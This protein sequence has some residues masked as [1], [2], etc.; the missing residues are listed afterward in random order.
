MIVK[1]GKGLNKCDLFR[2][3][4]MAAQLRFAK[5]CLNKQKNLWSKFL[6]TCKTKVEIFGFSVQ[7]QSC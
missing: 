4:K 2:S 6:W 1:S 5:L 3:Q 7:Q